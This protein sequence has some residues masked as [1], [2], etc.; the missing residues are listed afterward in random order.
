M[1]KLIG[2][3]HVALLPY[4]KQLESLKILN[5]EKVGRNKQY[6][7]GKDNILIKHYLTI[8]EELATI[9]YLESNFL[10][11]KLCEHLNN[12][13]LSNPL[14]L[15]GSYAKGYATE[16]SDI[17]LLSIGK[18]SEN[19]LNHIKKFEATFGKKVNIKTVTPENFDGAL[20]T[21]DILIKEVIASHIVL[22]NPDPFVTRLWRQYIER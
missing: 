17:D 12:I 13:D 4:L 18:L 5:S 10:I 11:K 8:T 14:I 9:N 21:G 2:T 22:C 1:A 6:R 16:E 3:S 19:H 20:Q 7:L 15:F